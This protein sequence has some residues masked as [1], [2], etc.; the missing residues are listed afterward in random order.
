MRKCEKLDLKQREEKIYYPL[1]EPLR[2]LDP[3]NNMVFDE[4]FQCPIAGRS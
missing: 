3:K 1:I 2:F 4:I